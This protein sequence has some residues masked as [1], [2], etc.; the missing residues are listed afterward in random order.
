MDCKQVIGGRSNNRAENSHLPNLIGTWTSQYRAAVHDGKK[1]EIGVETTALVIGQQDG[2]FF[3]GVAVWEMDGEVTV[4]SDIGEEQ[5]T[6]GDDGFIGLIG[7]DGTEITMAE[8]KDSGIY[9]GRLLDE[10]RMEIT[11]IESDVGD[12]VLLRTVFVR[13]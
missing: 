2:E 8:V 13:Q 5:V 9:R 12:A 7:F 11:Y 1:F 3:T 10:N 6:G 4:G